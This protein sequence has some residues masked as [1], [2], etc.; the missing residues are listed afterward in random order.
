MSSPAEEVKVRYV[1]IKVSTALSRSGLPDLD[2]ALNPYVGCYHSCIY[3]YAR[4][5]TRFKEVAENW[6]QVIYIK[7]NLEDV[8]R[9][10]VRV[11][12]R[13][14]VGV[15]T[16][17][18]P[19]QPI[20]ASEKLTRLSLNTLLMA[21]FRVDIQTK[22]PLVVRDLDILRRFRERVEVGFTITSMNDSVTSIIEPRA[23]PPSRRAEALETLHEN[24]ISTWVFLGPIIPGV[25]DSPESLREV[26]EVASSTSSTLYYDWIH[27]HKE[28]IP[29]LNTGLMKSGLKQV[30]GVSPEWRSRVEKELRNACE[31]FHVRCLPAF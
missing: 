8:L 6:G 13:G 1:R 29:S 3:C 30:K 7:E 22:S 5:Y 25:N 12:R 27:L 16:I 2:Y 21:G 23:P 20:E 9:R 19:Y 10:E 4:K 14:V 11:L 28:V 26:V 24:G 18:D 15:S 31:S 17:T